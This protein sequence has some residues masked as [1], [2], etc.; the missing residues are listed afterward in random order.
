MLLSP[1]SRTSEMFGNS[2]VCHKVFVFL[3]KIC[4]PLT[5]QKT[6]TPK[7]PPL[8]MQRSGSAACGLRGGGKRRTKQ[9]CSCSRVQLVPSVK[10]TGVVCTPSPQDRCQRSPLA[11]GAALL[12]PGRARCRG[13]SPRAHERDLTVLLLKNELM[14]LIMLPTGGKGLVG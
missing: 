7:I 3:L 12:V 4:A 6:Q 13:F 14:L 2:Q 5:L 9:R 11:G 8:A 1:P 10:V